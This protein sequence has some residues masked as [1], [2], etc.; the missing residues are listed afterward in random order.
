MEFGITF[1]GVMEPDRARKLVAQ[2]EE[3]GFAYC[4]FY[5]SHILWRESYP[6][7]A[8]CMEREY[9]RGSR[10]FHVKSIV[11]NRSGDRHALIEVHV[12]DRVEQ[13]GA[14]GD[15]ALECLSA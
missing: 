11:R 8:M 4:W 5:D 6:A 2:A 9:P 14:F 12:L 1:K 13:C 3:A 15:G 7:M 10:V